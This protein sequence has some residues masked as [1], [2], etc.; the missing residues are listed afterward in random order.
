MR[1]ANNRIRALPTKTNSDRPTVG[2]IKRALHDLSRNAQDSEQH[3]KGAA[4]RE[5]H[6][7]LRRLA[8]RSGINPDDAVRQSLAA[9]AL[10]RERMVSADG[11]APDHVSS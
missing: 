9:V 1:E 3:D 6:K 7:E 4:L 10:L 8:L 2:A 5:V 11:S